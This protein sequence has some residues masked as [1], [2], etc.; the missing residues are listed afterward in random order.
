MKR[1]IVPRQKGHRGVDSPRAHS[2][3]AHC[4]HRLCWQLLI[5]TSSAE[6]MQMKHICA[7][8]SHSASRFM[9]DST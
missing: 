8:T 4:L 9:I 3:Y 2:W 5:L 7:G 1:W 6:S